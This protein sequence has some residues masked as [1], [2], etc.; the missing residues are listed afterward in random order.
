MT[1]TLNRPPH[2]LPIDAPIPF[3]RLVGVEWR[4]A[5]DTRS[6]RWLLGLTA[7]VT[8]A[9][10]LIPLIAAHSIDQNWS[11]YLL[12]AGF[13]LATLLPV[14]AILTLTTEWT[15]RTVLTTFMQEPRR[16]RVIGAKVS[17]AG[18]LTLAAMVY[19]A[20]VTAVAL[21]IAAALGRDLTADLGPANVSGYALFIL[22]NMAMGVAFGALL[23]NTAAAIVLFFVLPTV[24]GFVG[25]A[26]HSVDRWVNTGTTF[27]WVQQGDYGGHVPNIVVSALLWIVAPLVVG[28]IR[29]VRRE[30]N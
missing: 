22:L 25:A 5:T 2:T 7:L 20:V 23:H 18:L 27:D 11:S 6:A 30:I 12:F 4:K 1:A 16:A 13:A 9:A 29:T 21:G 24:F 17:V 19:G 8:A 3:G 26:L 14:V 28:V 15:Q 10:M